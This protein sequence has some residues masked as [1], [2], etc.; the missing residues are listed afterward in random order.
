MNLNPFARDVLGAHNAARAEVGAPALRWNEELAQ[1]ATDYAQV[2][3][4]TGELVHAPREGRGTERENLQKGLIGWSPDRMIQDWAKEKN[5]FVPGNFPDVARD[6]N[7]LNVAHY[8]QM[9]WP[10][11]TEVGCGSVQGGGFNWFVC[12]YNP[13]GN[14]DG[15]PVGIPI[16]PQ[17]AAS[18][19]AQWLGFG[20]GPVSTGL[21]INVISGTDGGL[22]NDVNLD[23]ST[24]ALID[25]LFRGQ[26]PTSATQEVLVDTKV[27]QPTLPSAEVYKQTKVATSDKQEPSNPRPCGGG[28]NFWKAEEVY[29]AAKAEGD[30]GG[31]EYAKGLMQAAIGRQWQ[32]MEASTE[33]GEMLESKISTYSLGDFLGKMMD[34]YKELTGA[35]PPGYYESP[36]GFTTDIVPPDPAAPELPTQEVY[37]PDGQKKTCDVM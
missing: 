32:S 34:G 4:R 12:R 26:E 36:N 21:D 8:T 30:V 28:V 6:G 9:I 35:L 22:G 18:A 37:G 31:M 24:N 11:T 7:W 23:A 25:Q 10:T 19:V 29:K 5:N 13:G 27:E 20:V 33:A 16:E 15:K 1:H 2:L 3:A 14:K 17:Q